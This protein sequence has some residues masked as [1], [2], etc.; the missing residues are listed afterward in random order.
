MIK[1]LTTI[2][3]QHIAKLAHIGLTETETEK[4]RGQL[5]AILDFVGKL[6]EV[7]TAETKPLNQTTGLKNVFR[8]DVVIPSFSQ[9]EV[10]LNAPEKFKGYFKTKMILKQDESI[11]PN[12]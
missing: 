8:E 5:S 2:E 10:L 3:V 1:E 4:F 12:S 6:K 7:D 9:E 11:R